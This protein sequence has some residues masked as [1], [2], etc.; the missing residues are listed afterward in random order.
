[1]CSSLNTLKAEKGI[2]G[3]FLQSKHR[4]I[5][6][7][8]FHLGLKP[9]QLQESGD[10]SCTAQL[11]TVQLCLAGSH[12][13]LDYSCLHCT[14]LEGE[15]KSDA[16]PH[17]SPVQHLCCHVSPVVFLDPS[18]SV[19][20]KLGRLNIC[21]YR[22]MSMYKINR[23]GKNVETLSHSKVNFSHLKVQTKSGVFLHIIPHLVKWN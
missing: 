4:Q 2:M 3:L 6:F 18:L 20:L 17:L 10:R 13:M 21:M 14:A 15:G 7:K 16:D 1:M 22:W 5:L 12:T 9:V 11:S 23:R 19:T 8:F